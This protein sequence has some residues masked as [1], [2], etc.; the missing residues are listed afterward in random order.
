MQQPPHMSKSLL[1]PGPTG[2]AQAVPAVRC[3]AALGVHGRANSAGA[4]SLLCPLLHSKT[5]SRRCNAWRKPREPDPED[6][7]VAAGRF[8]DASQLRGGDV[9]DGWLGVGHQHHLAAPA[10]QLPGQGQHAQDHV[11]T[12]APHRAQ[13]QQGMQALY[14]PIVST[15]E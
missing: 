12:C 15:S 5:N 8:Q 10:Q 6:G 13:G 1:E 14:T 4:A 2:L 7:A 3:V 9:I 11:R